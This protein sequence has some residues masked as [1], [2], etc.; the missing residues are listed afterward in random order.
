[1]TS[2][3]PLVEVGF[4]ISRGGWGEEAYVCVCVCRD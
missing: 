4:G 1:M 2:A 3:N